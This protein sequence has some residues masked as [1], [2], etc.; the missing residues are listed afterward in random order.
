MAERKLGHQP[1][2][3]IVEDEWEDMYMI[4][5]TLRKIGCKDIFKAFDGEDAMN[6]LQRYRFDMLLIN[7]KLPKLGGVEIIKWC[8]EQIP[9]LP[10][11][12]ITGF[13]EG[14]PLVKEAMAINP[15]P[16][17]LNKPFTVESVTALLAQFGIGMPY[18]RPSE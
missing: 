5:E 11:V 6:Q 10:T 2:F 17:T 16:T 9:N 8:R 15:S 7:L 1:R 12:I 4:L 18:E 14:S 13:D 3:L